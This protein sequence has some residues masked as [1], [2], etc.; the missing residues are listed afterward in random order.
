MRTSFKIL[1]KVLFSFLL[2]YGLSSCVSQ[3]THDTVVFTKDSLILSNDSLEKVIDNK[4]SQIDNL[5]DELSKNRNTINKQQAR[6]ISLEENYNKLKNR[7]TDETKSLLDDI[8]ALQADRIEME[9]NLA[10]KQRQIDD[11]N[12]RLSERDAKMDSLKNSLSQA[13]VGFADK[14]LAVDI[15]NGKVYVSLSNQLLFSSGSTVIDKEGRE[16]LKELAIVLNT[17]VDINILIEGHTDNQAV[18]GGGGKRFR[19]NWDLSALRA[20]E[21]AK[22]LEESGEVNPKR[23]I[24]SGR[25]EYFPIEDGSTQEIRA[26]N[27][28]TEIIL[29]PKLDEIYK[30]IEN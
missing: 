13:L 25:S 21:V 19:D 11:I 2:I 23:I 26:K 28:R 10:K 9:S 6:Y 17:Q 24:A 7:T 12:K 15:R 22:F 3:S 29:T 18:K 4:I 20:T 8:E 30:M 5:N 14:G 27:R 16:A 1:Y